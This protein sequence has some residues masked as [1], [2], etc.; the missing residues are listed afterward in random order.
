MC[1]HFRKNVRHDSWVGKVGLD[2]QVSVTYSTIFDTASCRCYLIAGA[3][4][5]IAMK[6]PVRGPTLKIRT[7]GSEVMLKLSV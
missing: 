3:S 5:L 4:K 2:I 7:V 1:F 6:V